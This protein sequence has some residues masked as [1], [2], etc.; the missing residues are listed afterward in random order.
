MAYSQP[1]WAD[2]ERMGF[3]PQKALGLPYASKGSVEYAEQ[4]REHNKQRRRA[5][6]K[7]R[8]IQLF[9]YAIVFNP[10][11]DPQAKKKAQEQPKLLKEV[12]TVLAEDEAQ[13][14]TFASRDIPEGYTEKLDEVEIFVR[15][16]ARSR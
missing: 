12:T 4:W 13:A 15:P 16:F 14:R 2:L 6:D 10:T 1:T 5:M 8:D 9:Q 3:D 7:V 11:Y